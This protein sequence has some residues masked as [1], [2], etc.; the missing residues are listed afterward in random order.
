M[1]LLEDVRDDIGV[2]AEGQ[3]GLEKRMDSMENHMD[4]MENR[5]D[6]MENR[7]EKMQTDI[8]DIKFKVDQKVSYDEFHK[9]ERRVI[10]LEKTLLRR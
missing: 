2:I 9:L 5:M 7:M 4:G 10:T 3:Q 1:M 6:G 8:T